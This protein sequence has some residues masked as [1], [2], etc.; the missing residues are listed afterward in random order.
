MSPDPDR[1]IRRSDEG[2]ASD[3]LK[4]YGIQPSR[5]DYDVLTLHRQENLLDTTASPRHH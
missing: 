3:D 4:K 5:G 1:A 2:C